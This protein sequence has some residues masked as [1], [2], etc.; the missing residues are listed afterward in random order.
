LT[1]QCFTISLKLPPAMLLIKNYLY[2]D[3]L[4]VVYLEAGANRYVLWGDVTSL[5]G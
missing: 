2:S 1:D 4:F 5:I 3:N